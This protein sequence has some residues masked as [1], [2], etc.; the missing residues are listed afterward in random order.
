M[1]VSRE[2]TAEEL[3]RLIRGLLNNAQRQIMSFHL[4]SSML[5]DVGLFCDSLCTHMNRLAALEINSDIRNSLMYVREA[6][7]YLEQARASS[8]SGVDDSYQ[9][10]TLQSTSGRP[11]F[12][13]TSEQLQYFLG[14]GFT[15]PIIAKMLGV[16]VRT[17]RRRMTD[18]G[19][20]SRAR[21]SDVSDSDL[22]AV[23]K[24]LKEQYPHCGYRILDGLLKAKGILVQQIRVREAVLRCDPEGVAARWLCLSHPR[25]SYTVSGPLALW[26]ID[27]NHKLIRY[28]RIAACYISTPCR[29]NGSMQQ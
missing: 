5:A 6:T 19:L 8:S 12:C 15:V 27:G 22:D 25:C 4:D 13:V 2:E 26:H 16:S 11:R 23:V 17:V 29:L 9:A 21:F 28:V 3:R 24:E 14:H 20:N 7:R 1:T 10:T 18:F